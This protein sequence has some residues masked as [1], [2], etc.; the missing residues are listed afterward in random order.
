MTD[1]IK[2]K[3]RWSGYA[4]PVC[5]FVFRVPT[6]H[7]GLGVI[8]PDCRYLLKLPKTGQVQDP[9]SGAWVQAK[10]FSGKSLREEK[11]KPIV[12]RT[13]EEAQDD[14]T[15]E[16]AAQVQA[17]GWQRAQIDN[18]LAQSTPSWEVAD[19]AAGEG[20]LG[21]L[22]IWIAIGGSLGLGVVAIGAWLMIGTMDRQQNP[23][24]NVKVGAPGESNAKTQKREAQDELS[25]E[26]VKLRE[27]IRE[28]IKQGSLAMD[29]AKQGLALFFSAQTADELGAFVRNPEVTIP[30]MKK[31]YQ[32]HPYQKVDYK[33][34]GYGGEVQMIDQ[35]V[36][37]RVQMQ[38]YRVKTVAFERGSNGIL[39][40]WE[41]WVGWTEMDWAELFNKRPAEPVEV[42]VLCT[43]DDYYN[44]LFNDD[45]KWRPVLMKALGE[46]R[47]IYGYIDSNNPKMMRLI[48]DLKMKSDVAVTIKIRY[49]EGSVASN[50]VEIVEHI[51]TGWI[52]LD[53]E[54]KSGH[55]SDET[56]SAATN[57]EAKS[58]AA[59]THE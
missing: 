27:E 35:L 51:H 50:Q 40:D 25:A 10:G 31:W 57:D 34:I 26:E 2:K 43:P 20:S 4:C 17:E 55:G 54:Q 32:T 28:S 44:R 7:D 52:E 15:A 45:K 16:E 59:Q 58:S 30:R 36:S 18:Q 53:T 1:A 39:V 46:D 47:P 5:R 6:E 41:S 42:R 38:D 11:A 22:A 19:E 37:V 33:E 56:K 12:C 8:C 23:G 3:R 9:D 21:S 49:P 29:E 13:M 48:N 14:L 24:G